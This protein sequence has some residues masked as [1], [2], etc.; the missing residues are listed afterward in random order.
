M[1]KFFEMGKE[2]LIKNKTGK[3]HSAQKKGKKKRLF[4]HLYEKKGLK[5]MES[6]KKTYSFSIRTETTKNF[7]FMDIGGRF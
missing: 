6:S 7:S 4:F 1:E 5:E 3:Q 2:N